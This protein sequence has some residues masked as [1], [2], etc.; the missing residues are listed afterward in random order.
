MT[1][2]KPGFSFILIAAYLFFKLISWRSGD[3]SCAELIPCP[4]DSIDMLLASED[5]LG[6]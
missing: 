3:A 4:P 6:K 5:V 1:L 2:S